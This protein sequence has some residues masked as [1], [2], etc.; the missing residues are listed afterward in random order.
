METDPETGLRQPSARDRAYAK[1]AAE[2]AK[3]RRVVSAILWFYVVL[4]LIALAL[5]ISNPINGIA[6]VLGV[7]I[8][9]ALIAVLF[10]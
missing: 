4:G 1:F 7:A 8:V 2:E 10:F 5:L 6:F 3:A 9:T